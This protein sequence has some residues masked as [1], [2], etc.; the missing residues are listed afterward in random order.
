M[1]NLITIIPI[2]EFS[3]LPLNIFN[4]QD[5]YLPDR[6]VYFNQVFSA[7]IVNSG[8][9]E[10]LGSIE[11]EM[12]ESIGP[13]ML[14]SI[15]SVVA[16]HWLLSEKQKRES[17]RMLKMADYLVTC[18]IITIIITLW[19][20]PWGW[21]SSSKILYKLFSTIQFLWRFDMVSSVMLSLAIT[22]TIGALRRY[23]P[24]RGMAVALLAC[25]GTGLICIYTIDGTGQFST[26]ENKTETA[27]MISTDY[28]YLYQDDSL[29]DIEER[30]TVVS[31]SK[32]QESKCLG[33]IRNG[34][35]EEFYLEVSYKSNDSWL[36]VPQYYYPGYR[37]YYGTTELKTERGTSG[38]VRVYLPSEVDSTEKFTVKFAEPFSWR[39]AEVISL[40]A[41][42]VFDITVYAERHKKSKCIA[43][44][45]QDQYFEI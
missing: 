44:V 34:T 1:I 11:N 15:I 37:A 9:S 43:K 29:E 24:Q 27:Y 18:S 40:I 36:E 8:G 7:F 12:P 19:I 45:K 30:G 31:F 42:V 32:D 14:I 38:T 23:Y 33:F 2:V 13:V 17:K 16:I 20:M 3:K 21:F 26:Y 22:I 28:N 41:L 35:T 6:T 39:M 5:V 25:G 4:D 10:P